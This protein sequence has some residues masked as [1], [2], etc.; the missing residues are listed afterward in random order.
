MAEAFKKDKV[1]AA[2]IE[3]LR[4]MAPPAL[5]AQKA[6]VPA[7]LIPQTKTQILMY[8]RP[9]LELVID[10][11]IMEVEKLREQGKRDRELESKRAKI[12]D[13]NAK[14]AHEEQLYLQTENQ[15]IKKDIGTMKATMDMI[16]KRMI[17]MA[18][19]LEL[20]HE[21]IIMQME[22]IRELQI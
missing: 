2:R 21:E 22:D 3:G 6:Q 14:I 9:R 17:G 19:A 5:W 20:Q 11:I 7:P 15:K 10:D 18:K 1:T 12:W 4:P 16:E 13:N 8:T